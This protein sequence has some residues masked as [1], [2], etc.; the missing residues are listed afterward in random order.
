MALEF[1][2][3]IKGFGFIAPIRCLEERFRPVGPRSKPLAS[4][5]SLRQRP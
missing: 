4:T 5:S 1:Y 3:S 2:D